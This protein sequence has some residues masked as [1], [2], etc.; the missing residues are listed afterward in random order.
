MN[1]TDE[2]VVN[3]CRRYDLLMKEKGYNQLYIMTTG[4]GM[5]VSS[6]AV[7]PGSSS[8]IASIFHPYSM[9]ELW[10]LVEPVM[11]VRPEFKTKKEDWRSVHPESAE[12]YLAAMKDSRMQDYFFVASTAALETTRRRKGKNVSYVATQANSASPVR[13]WEILLEKMEERPVYRSH[14][15]SQGNSITTSPTVDERWNEIFMHDG[16]INLSMLATCRS[17]QDNKISRS[18]LQMILDDKDF[19]P[20]LTDNERITLL[21]EDGVPV[22]QVWLEGKYD[23]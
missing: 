18:I 22:N 12:I 14:R 21:F 3:F 5:G 11:E 16:E 15:D 23:R 7:Y 2:I 13:V 17:L 8:R 19:Y 6:L 4:G 20:A 1:P 9:D 10:D